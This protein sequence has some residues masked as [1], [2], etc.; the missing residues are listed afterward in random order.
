[1]G[2]Q[3]LAARRGVDRGELADPVVRADGARTAHLI[4]VDR[5]VLLQD[6]DVD[7][8]ADL[9]TEPLAPRSALL[10]DVETPRARAGQAYDPEAQPVLAPLGR[11]LDEST[12]LH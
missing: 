4:Q 1:M 8:L 3:D 2:E 11:L 7:G 10:G 5:E 6:G 9:L 12:P